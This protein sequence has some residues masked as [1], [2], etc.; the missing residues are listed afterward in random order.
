MA[1]C[2]NIAG[3]LSDTINSAPIQV[4]VTNFETSLKKANK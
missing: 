3:Q 2:S 1:Y 4:I